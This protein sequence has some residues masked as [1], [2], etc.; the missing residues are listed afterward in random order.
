MTKKKG[1]NRAHGDKAARRRQQRAALQ[2]A[3]VNTTTAK[4]RRQDVDS[5]TKLDISMTMPAKKVARSPNRAL[6]KQRN[7]LLGS[8]ESP[9]RKSN[10]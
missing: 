5:A 2:P 7:P 3:S 6:P 8:A 10:A 4:V 9:D 1:K